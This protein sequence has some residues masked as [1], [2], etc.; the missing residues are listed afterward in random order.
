MLDD[1]YG[2]CQ[3]EHCK[4]TKRIRLA[5]VV[6]HIVPV[7]VDWS[8][9][10]VKSNLM[11]VNFYCHE[12]IHG[13]LGKGGPVAY[14]HNNSKPGWISNP[15]IPI[16]I[17]SGPPAAGKTTY[18]NKIATDGDIVIDLDEI[19][20]RVLD[21]Q[22]SYHDWDRGKIGEVLQVR[23]QILSD[24]SGYGAAYI[25]LT[26]PK[27]KDRRW[28]ID[29]MGALSIVLETPIEMCIKRLQER[30]GVTRTAEGIAAGWWK[31]YERMEHETIIRYKEKI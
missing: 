21:N 18:A 31:D 8:L 7:D 15:G 19:A 13:R 24:L 17:I 29:K 14:Q 10:L 11:A 30:G 9:R 1:A 26:V 5:D 22:G 16:L 20:N 12:R 3:C 23:N 28:W 6:H 4:L 2:V 25:I 27:V